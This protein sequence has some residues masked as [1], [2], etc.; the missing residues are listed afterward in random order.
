MSL[1][2]AIQMDPI[3][4]IDIEGDST[5]ALALEAQA[6]GHALFHYL[7]Q[8]L[9]LRDG[10]VLARAQPLQVRREAGNF[11][12]KGAEETLDLAGVDVVLMRQDPPFDM[13]YITA[14]HV[15]EHIHPQT[16]VVNDPV[17]V[18]NA[19]EKLFVTHFDG[20]MPPTLITSNRDDIT[21]FRAEHGD[22]IVKPLYGNGGAGVFHITPGDENLTALLELFTD[23]YREPVI[24]QRYLP[25]VRQGDKRI[26]LV[27]GKPVGAINRV[28]AAGEARSNMHVGGTPLKSA[29]TVR[30]QDICAAIGPAL[31]EQGLIFVGID[32]IGDYL[33]EINVT[34]PTG[35]QEIDRFDGLNL[36][37]LIWDAI[38]AR[39]AETRQ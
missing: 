33:T 10:R 28:P 14:T 11:F 39:H 25:E 12:T 24:A 13:A 38:E 3:E 37:A 5:F 20:L 17:S 1:A 2:V 27:D 16:L 8:N 31:R 32:V 7:P 23:L 30:E 35:I 29:L 22:I 9:S 4:S 6:R 26:I 15:L 18:R 36:P 21:A 34:S 19:P